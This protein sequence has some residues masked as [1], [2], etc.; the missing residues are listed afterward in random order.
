MNRLIAQQSLAGARARGRVYA[1]AAASTATRLRGDDS[2]AIVVFG[3]FFA[4]MVLGML[5][6][7]VGLA[8][9]IHLRERMQDAADASAFAAAVVHA[10]GMNVLALIN[11]IMAA[12]MSVLVTLRIIELLIIIAQVILYML[13]WLGGATAAIASA[14]EVVRQTVTEIADNAEPVIQ[15]V[16]K[17]LHY[18]G[19][20]VRIIT[21]VGANLTV[22]GKVAGNYGQELLEPVGAIAIPARL[23]LPV[24]DDQYSYLCGKAGTMASVL[25][26]LPFEKVLPTKVRNV[27]G[28]AAHKLTSAGSSWFCG[29]GDPPEI[30]IDP[31]LVPFPQSDEMA[32]CRDPDKHGEDSLTLCQKAEEVEGRGE[33]NKETG[34][35]RQ[36]EKVCMQEFDTELNPPQLFEFDPDSYCALHGLEDDVTEADCAGTDLPGRT[37]RVPSKATAY[38]TRVSNARQHCRPDGKKQDYWWI[39]RQVEVVWDGKTNSWL[40]KEGGEVTDEATV[41]PSEESKAMK[42]RGP[43]DVQADYFTGNGLQWVNAGTDWNTDD[44]AQPFCVVNPSPPVTGQPTNGMRTEVTQVLGCQEMQQPYKKKAVK[45]VNVGEDQIRDRVNIGSA[46][47]AASKNT[48]GQFKGVELDQDQ[49]TESS[50]TKGQKNADGSDSDG[51]NDMVPFRFEKK[52][53]LGTSDMQIRSLVMSKSLDDA[54]IVRNTEGDEN[55]HEHAQ[56][57]VEITKWGSDDNGLAKLRDASQLYGRFAIAQAEYYF[58]VD[59]HGGEAAPFALWSHKDDENKTNGSRDYLW[60]MGWT[61]RMRRFRLKFGDADGESESGADS[62]NN[63]NLTQ[64]FGGDMA[65]DAL[66]GG[67]QKSGKD[68]SNSGPEIPCLG[69]DVCEQIKPLMSSFDALFLH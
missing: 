60:Y 67:G 39:E 16:I 19:D 1:R 56:R 33:P 20:V 24:E 36:G 51:S 3:I 32:K 64:N 62:S 9:V 69:I 44:L 26:M 66:A 37:V 25:V 35:C 12:I 29:D 52:H 47:T 13:S 5:Y 18:T 53:K 41:R 42:F 27:V 59:A 46:E 38:G 28:E 68:V 31:G 40:P 21:P 10:R 49:A 63:S 6:Y 65:K 30:D 43:C 7:F 4:V 17:V 50:S 48:G 58:D 54:K 14:L 45:P 2:G 61:A 57:V 15:N 22:I 11:M 34:T 8:A 55:A 23:T